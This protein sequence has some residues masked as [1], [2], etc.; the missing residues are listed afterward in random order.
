MRIVRI[1]FYQ[2]VG[3][4]NPVQQSGNRRLLPD[5]PWPQVSGK[6]VAELWAAEWQGEQ[7]LRFDSYESRTRMESDARIVVAIPP[8]ISN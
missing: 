4:L 6:I 8:K 3:D 5:P 2:T 7:S 1:T